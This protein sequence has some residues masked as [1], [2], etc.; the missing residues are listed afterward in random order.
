MR[1]IERDEPTCARLPFLAVIVG[2]SI[3]Y[4]IHLAF[5]YNNALL[6]DRY[7]KS[8]AAF[9]ARSGS[10]T[11]S[12]FTTLCSVLPLVGSKLIPLRQFGLIFTIVSIVAYAFTMLFFN[13]LLMLVGPL[14]TRRVTSGAGG[15]CGRVGM[16]L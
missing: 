15:E 9:L 8:R 16:E 5:A 7:Y 1:A 13:P 6:A 4:L 10:I 3:D 14:H 11:A 12:A 2:V